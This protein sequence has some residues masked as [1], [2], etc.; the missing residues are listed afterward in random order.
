MLRLRGGCIASPVPAIFAAHAFA[1]PGQLYLESPETLA[2]ASPRDARA[3]I[4][5]LG[6]SLVDSPQCDAETLLNAQACKIL[7]RFADDQHAKLLAPCAD[8]RLELREEEL[9]ALVGADTVE[10]A[11]SFF[12]GPFDTIKLR[13][14]VGDAQ[15]RS[16]VFHTDFSKRTMQIA[17]ND[18]AEYEGGRLVFATA[19]GFVLPTRPQGSTT[20]HVNSIVHGVTALTSGVR[21]GLFFCDTRGHENN[22]LL[23]YLLEPSMSQFSFFQDAIDVLDAATDDELAA[24]ALRYARFLRSAGGTNA[25]AA[26]PSF[27]IE[28]AWR[29]H[30]LHPLIYAR[31]CGEGSLLDHSVDDVAQYPS[32]ARGSGAAHSNDDDDDNAALALGLDLVAAMRRQQKFMRAMVAERGR[33][34]RE[35][36]LSDAIAEYYVFLERVKHSEVPLEPTPIVDL[37]WHTH[38]QF[39]A[40]Y[41][42]ECRR[43]AGSFVDHDD[44]E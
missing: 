36:V 15:G 8:L 23:D 42:V 11:A 19:E 37:V 10:R 12:D 35:E 17:L 30:L 16:V 2:T 4:A 24:V 3:L 18:E 32:D 34:E 14:A 27:E 25:A 28:L 33:Y 39:P 20:V 44:D 22:G 21:Y 41:A 26:P 7:T 43:L 5:T 9:A 31:A 6:G 40:R 29:T 38:Q 13:R 1:C